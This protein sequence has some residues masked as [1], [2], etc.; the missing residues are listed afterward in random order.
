MGLIICLKNA[1][2]A[3]NT[4]WAYLQYCN[5]ADDAENSEDVYFNMLGLFADAP[6]VCTI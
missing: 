6:P 2:S 1:E 5:Y 3:I 4:V